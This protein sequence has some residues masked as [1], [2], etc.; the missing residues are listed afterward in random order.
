MDIV[1]E[2]FEVVTIKVPATFNSKTS[3]SGVILFQDFVPVLKQTENIYPHSVNRLA[4]VMDYVFP[5]R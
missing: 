1:N 3:A 4:S 2:A 5:V